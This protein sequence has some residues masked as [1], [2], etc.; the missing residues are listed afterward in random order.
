MVCTNAVFILLIEKKTTFTENKRSLKHKHFSLLV[1]KKYIN[2]NKYSVESFG[3]KLFF[4]FFKTHFHTI[5]LLKIF[6][7]IVTIYVYL[8]CVCVCMCI[9]PSCIS[10]NMS[11]HVLIYT[12]IILSH[13]VRKEKKK[14]KTEFT[15]KEKTHEYIAIWKLYYFTFF[16]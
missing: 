1:N 2:L 16:F 14:Q 11:A 9:N 4:F 7:W 10:I 5:R 3:L 8:L 6:P 12:Y 15:R 13:G